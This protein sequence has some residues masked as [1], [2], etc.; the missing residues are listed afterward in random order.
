MELSSLVSVGTRRFWTSCGL[1]V[2]I[3]I[4]ERSKMRVATRVPKL[5]E[6]W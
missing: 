3:I 6:L 2:D 5:R 4:I 1:H